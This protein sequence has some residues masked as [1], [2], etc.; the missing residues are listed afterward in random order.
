M[1]VDANIL[2]RCALG[3]GLARLA[4]LYDGGAAL[5]TPEHMVDECVRVIARNAGSKMDSHLRR[6]EEALTLCEVLASSAYAPLRAVAARR[7]GQGGQSDWPLLAAAI[8]LDDAIWTNDRDLFG[9]GVPVWSTPNVLLSL[10]EATL[11]PPVL[12]VA[13]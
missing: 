3:A 13:P 7:L 12:P 10:G 2:L 4:R 1:I 6:L 9:V 5:R 8:L 11:D